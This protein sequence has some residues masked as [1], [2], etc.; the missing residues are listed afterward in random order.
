MMGGGEGKTRQITVDG[1][2]YRVNDE[3]K[4]ATTHHEAT[5]F[6]NGSGQQTVVVKISLSNHLVAHHIHAGN[7]NT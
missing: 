7:D 5:T 2:Q 3:A 6:G 1:V 4:T